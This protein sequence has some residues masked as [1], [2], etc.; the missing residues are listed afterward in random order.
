MIKREN[1]RRA[2]AFQQR[3]YAYAPIRFVRKGDVIS[4]GV[5]LLGEGWN[6]ARRFIEL[7]KEEGK[8]V[9]IPF[10]NSVEVFL[11]SGRH[12]IRS[13]LHQHSLLHYAKWHKPENSKE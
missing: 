3:I 1:C 7:P 13:M 8:F 6:I 4:R 2:C 11:N 10:L 9:A 12:K 5:R